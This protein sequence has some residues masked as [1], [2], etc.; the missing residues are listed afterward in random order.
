MTTLKNILIGITAILL[1][2]SCAVVRQGEVGVK[3]KLGKLDPKTME[4]G[5]RLFN[6]LTTTV[7]KI[8]IRTVNVEIQSNLP[9]K[10]GLNVQSV[11]SILYHIKKEN[12]SEIIENI[13]TN[14]EEVVIKSVFRSASAD[15]C[16]RFY[17]KDMHT[18][19][20][21]EIEDEIKTRM[22]DL[23][24]SRG[25][26]IEAVLLKTIQLPPGL[27][28]AVEDK[29]EAEQ[30]AQRMEFV[31][32]RERLEAD[33]RKVEAE[34]IRDAQKILQE[35]ISPQIIQWQSIEAFKELAKSPGSRVIIT[36][37]K[38]PF[39]IEPEGGN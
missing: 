8:P 18:I 1:I 35:G 38:A 14:Y 28:M 17:A 16:S 32:Q 12:A 9:S 22:Q 23:L 25:F 21:A 30:E 3:R 20:R 6:P 34:G 13:G 29:L 26:E 11:I 19:K 27:Y 36:D 39:L 15:V 2:S 37:G 4:S 10:E 31:L 5:A 24:A 33:R 7:I